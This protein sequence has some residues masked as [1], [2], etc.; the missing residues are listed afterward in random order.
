MNNQNEYLNLFGEEFVL[1]L[2][3]EMREPYN[4]NEL[5]RHGLASLNMLTINI[6]LDNCKIEVKN[7]AL[8]AMVFEEYKDIKK[9]LIS[10]LKGTHSSFLK[11]SPLNKYILKMIFKYENEEVLYE[12]LEA[13]YS[14]K[15]YFTNKMLIDNIKNNI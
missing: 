12:I 5:D 9:D 11:S 6:I 8:E 7:Y 15:E 3:E 4:V 2:I 10:F 1:E 14:L 13:N